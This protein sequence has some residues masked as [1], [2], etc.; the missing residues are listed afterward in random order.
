MFNVDA[1]SY[2]T[3][4]VDESIDQGLAR[5]DRDSL[6]DSESAASSVEDAFSSSLP[7]CEELK[8]FIR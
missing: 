2:T 5:Q 7:N 1:A 6:S 4:D 3:E 8:E